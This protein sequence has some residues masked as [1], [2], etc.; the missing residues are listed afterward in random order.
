M[1]IWPNKAERLVSRNKD[2]KLTE[3]PIGVDRVSLL[4]VYL[5][6]L[7]G[8]CSCHVTCN[9]SILIF[10]LTYFWKK[11]NNS[12]SITRKSSKVTTVMGAPVASGIPIQVYATNCVAVWSLLVAF[13]SR[14]NSHNFSRARF[15]LANL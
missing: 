1:T 5:F 12:F 15:L 14:S 4:F 6:A 2:E 13:L 11:V 7:L 9:L 8:E 3:I 10:L